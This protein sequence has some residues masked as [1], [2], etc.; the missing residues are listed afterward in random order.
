MTST[1]ACGSQRVARWVM[2]A[3]Y[4]GRVAGPLCGGAIASPFRVRATVSAN[5]ETTPTTGR[6]RG[7]AMTTEASAERHAETPYSPGA[8][9]D[10][11]AAN[12]KRLPAAAPERPTEYRRPARPGAP[13]RLRTTI[14][15]ANT[16][17]SAPAT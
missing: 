8:P 11:R 9:S 10:G 5:A 17:G 3:P 7:P 15:L 2:F 13:P 16:N 4:T 6:R 12:A 14:Q 1:R